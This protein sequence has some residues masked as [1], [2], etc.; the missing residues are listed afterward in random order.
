MVRGPSRDEGT[1][2]KGQGSI[3]PRACPHPS[4][5]SLLPPLV[6]LKVSVAGLVTARVPPLL[7]SFLS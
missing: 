3:L 6:M 5:P 2:V 1:M 7:P 4:P